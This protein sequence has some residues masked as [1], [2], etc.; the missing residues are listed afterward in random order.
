[1]PLATLGPV[2]QTFGQQLPWWL[3]ATLAAAAALWRA[4]GLLERASTARIGSSAADVSSALVRPMAGKRDWL[5]LFLGCAVLLIVIDFFG[6]SRGFFRADDFAFIQDAREPQPFGRYLMMYHNDHSLP[7]Y[8][9]QVWV[10]LR[11]LGN[12]ASADA[13]AAAFNLVGFATYLALLLS[14]CWVLHELGS[15]RLVLAM[16]CVVVWTWPGWGEF[17]SGLYTITVYP[18][19]GVLGF[20]SIAY[21]LRAV[22]RRSC[23]DVAWAIVATVLAAGLDVSGMWVFPAGLLLAA[24][25]HAHSPQ[26][27]LRFFLAGALLAAIAAALFHLIGAPHEF[28]ARELVQN[29]SGSTLRGSFVTTLVA[30]GWRI[31]LS[32][33]GGIGGLIMSA[34]LPPLLE[35][36]ADKIPAGS[37]AAFLI[38][39]L[40]IAVA[41]VALW[42]AILAARK[43]AARDRLILVALGSIV[44]VLLA[45]IVLA[46]SQFVHLPF[47]LWPAKYKAVPYC[48]LVLTT[49]FVIDRACA[50]SAGGG[51]TYAKPLL[52]A[53][54][55]AL[56]LTLPQWFVEKAFAINVPWRTGGRYHNAW[57]A[58]ARRHD[59]TALL[60]DARQLLRVTGRDELPLPK[61]FAGYDRY[62]FLEVGHGIYGACFL[63]GDL[64]GVGSDLSAKITLMPPSFAPPSDIQAAPKQIPR[65]APLFIQNPGDSS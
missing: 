12:A 20:A 50:R 8:R 48:C 61:G 60:S 14:G 11:V 65:M 23:A 51:W 45:M 24:L 58:E 10:V 2:Y 59:F 30:N 13:L 29:P 33:L 32:L 53:S 49:C 37:S 63:P 38:I 1:M 17:T 40:E 28:A 44:F 42:I 43:L 21:L 16:F 41:A 25:L 26:R 46:R 62:P 9:L 39:I 52:F 4:S 35:L 7:L 54:A 64:F 27:E 6:F 18:Q 57:I 22:R 19:I 5:I 31:P 34:F 55:I 56:W 36:L 15:R 3:A 47:L